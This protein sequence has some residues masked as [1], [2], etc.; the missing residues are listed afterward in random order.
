MKKLKTQEVLHGLS[1]L[2]EIIV[3]VVILTA[4]FASLVGLVQD[5]SPAQ[6]VA[7]PNKFSDFLSTAATLVIGVEFVKMLCNHTMGA[8]LEIMLLAIARQMI[9]QH[10]TPVENLVAVLSV[11]ILYMVRKFLFI[12]ILDRV[13]FRSFFQ[14][15]WE[16]E[17]AGERE[18]NPL[19]ESIF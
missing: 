3:G 8:V 9:V 15:M 17:K 7:D 2:F 14:H 10:T 16:K 1:A 6:L 11:A 5:I 13:R 12:P 4:L 18:E 19:E